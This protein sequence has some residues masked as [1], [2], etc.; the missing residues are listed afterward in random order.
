YREPP[1]SPYSTAELYNTYPYILITGAR[2][3]GFFHT[4]NRQIPWLRELDRDP[5][6]E[7]HPETA[8]IEGIGQ[9]D[10]VVIE[11][12]RGKV[13][14]RAKLSAG[15]DPRVVSAQHAWWFPEKEGPGHGW[16]ESNINILTDNSYESCDPAMGATHVRTLLCRI[17]P[18]KKNGG[19]L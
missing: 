17:Y 8:K 7:I 6:V 14:Q 18:E 16:D 5:V 4:E 15:I 11:S 13:R 10:W 12:P 1:E 2:S 3:P 9:G 19:N